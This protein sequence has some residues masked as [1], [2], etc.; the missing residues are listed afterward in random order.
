LIFKIPSS[1]KF[2]LKIYLGKYFMTKAVTENSCIDS[3]FIPEAEC[4][5]EKFEPFADSNFIKEFNRE[6]TH[7]H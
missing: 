5:Y 7:A 2:N 4:L 1:A 3:I 6:E